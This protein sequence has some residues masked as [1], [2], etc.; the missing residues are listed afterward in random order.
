MFYLG[1]QQGYPVLPV[2]FNMEVGGIVVNWIRS[3]F[4]G[5]ARPVKPKYVSIFI[6]I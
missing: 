6:Y 2:L 4:R 1:V 3:A 5:S